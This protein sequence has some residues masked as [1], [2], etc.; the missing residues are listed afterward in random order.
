MTLTTMATT[1]SVPT[2]ATRGRSLLDLPVEVRLKIYSHLLWP[3]EPWWPTRRH[4][5]DYR[6][7]AVSEIIHPQILRTCRTCYLEGV[8]F[9]YSKCHFSVK[10]IDDLYSFNMD[11]IP[12]IGSI[13][14]ALIK[15][16]DSHSLLSN[17]LLRGNHEKWIVPRHLALSGIKSLLRA[18]PN[19]QYFEL[20]LDSY[21]R[22]TSW[23]LSHLIQVLLK[24]HSTLTRAITYT[25]TSMMSG[26]TRSVENHQWWVLVGE[27]E[28]LPNGKLMDGYVSSPQRQKCF[29]RRGS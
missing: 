4:S 7:R 12:K 29:L 25:G 17:I 23:D 20:C 26:M 14:A 3:A 9:M 24:S 8:E 21:F 2:A 11:F 28:R 19:L 6:N 16:I 22:T 1:T 5:R 13:N 18:C 10:T 27:G 15:S